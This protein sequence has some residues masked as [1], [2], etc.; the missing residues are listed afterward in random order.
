[1]LA[2]QAFL[3]M[4]TINLYQGTR[5][6][7]SFSFIYISLRDVVKRNLVIWKADQIKKHFILRLYAGSL[8]IPFV[9]LTVMWYERATKAN[10]TIL[11][12]AKNIK[13]KVKVAITS[14]IGVASVVTTIVLT[15]IKV[16]NNT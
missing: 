4:K 7:A 2:D 11:A 9:L 10:N 3:S 6:G 13:I 8:F 12:I 1:M 14:A 5:A 15:I 16:N